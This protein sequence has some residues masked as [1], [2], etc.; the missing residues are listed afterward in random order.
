MALSTD[1][2]DAI[3]TATRA[4]QSALDDFAAT[5]DCEGA[6]QLGNVVGSLMLA[7][8]YKASAIRIRTNDMHRPIGAEISDAM[9]LEE[10]TDRL[11]REALAVFGA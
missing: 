8:E 3:V 2:R 9:V 10:S 5:G 1:Q 7:C 11:I 6:E 4:I